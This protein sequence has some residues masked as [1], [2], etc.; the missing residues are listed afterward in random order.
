MVDTSTLQSLKAKQLPS[1]WPKGLLVFVL[2]LFLLAL[3]AYFSLD[4]WNQNQNIKLDILEKEFQNTRDSFTIE[5]EQKVILF[6]KKLNA[7][8][9]LLNDHIHFSNILSLF[10]EL[11]HPQVYYFDLDFVANK[12]YIS[13]NGVAEN[14]EIL[15][16]AISGL[17]NDPTRIKAV[18]LKDMQIDLKNRAN[19]SIDVYIQPNI[20]KYQLNEGN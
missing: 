6:E 16:E 12:G 15:S 14:Q 3:G 17:V 13:L 5:E 8:K 10:E 18:V 2:I 11:T 20:L 19:F 4:F 7:L 1:T 9:D